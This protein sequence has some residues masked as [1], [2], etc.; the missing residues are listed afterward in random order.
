MLLW[1]TV[2]IVVRLATVIRLLW[3]SCAIQLQ[4]IH[5]LVV[6]IVVVVVPWSRALSKR[7]C[8]GGY[9]RSGTTTTT[10]GTATLLL[11]WRVAFSCPFSLRRRGTRSW[12]GWILR[13][14]PICI[15]FG[16]LLVTPVFF[17]ALCFSWW[18][19]RLLFV[20]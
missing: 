10:A 20:C 12:S 8:S 17:F 3:C 9:A 11:S 13:L 6:P 19:L 7:L 4:R 16:T 5:P 1:S 2:R 14:V 18:R 15:R